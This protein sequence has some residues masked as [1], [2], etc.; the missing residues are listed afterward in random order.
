MNVSVLLNYKLLYSHKRT[1]LSYAQHPDAIHGIW[2]AG[3]GIKRWL[4]SRKGGG[5]GGTEKDASS[6]R[7]TTQS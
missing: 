1:L 5:I 3:F 2:K 7:K 6:K 4:H